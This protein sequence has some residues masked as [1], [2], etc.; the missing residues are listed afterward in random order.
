MNVYQET[1]QFAVCKMFMSLNLV[2]IL[3]YLY[4][5]ENVRITMSISK[6]VAKETY[7]VQQRTGALSI[8]AYTDVMLHFNFSRRKV[9]KWQTIF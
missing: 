1:I 6:M 3:R 5:V 2:R 8:R 7:N 9:M 4:A